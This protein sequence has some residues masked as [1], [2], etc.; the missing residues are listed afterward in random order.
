M[1]WTEGYVSEVN[2]TYG[3]Y[4]ELSPLKLALGTLI[5]LAQPIDSNQ[6]FT[7]CELACGQGYTTNIL[8]ATYPHAQ[9]YANDFNPNHIATARDLAAAAGMN[10]VKFFDDSFEEFLE[11]DL[12]QFDFISLHGIYSWISTKNRQAIVNFIRRNLKVGGLVYVSYNALPGWA[13]AMP[14]QALMLRH[15]ERISAPILNR[16]E[17][18]IDFAGQLMEANA[19]YFTQNPIL[20]SRHERLKDQNRYYLAHEY[21]NQEWNSFYFDEVAK[22]LEEAK[23]NYVGSANISDHLDVINIPPKG[24]EKLAQISDPIYREVV[25]DF[26]INTQFRRDIFVRGSIK[27]TPIEQV[28]KLQSMGLA[29]VVPRSKVKFTHQF[30]VGEVNLQ[31]AVYGAICDALDQNHLTFGQLQNHPKTTGIS[32]NNLYQAV[33]ILLGIGYIHPAVDEQTYQQR[34]KFTDAFNNAV[35]TKAINSEEYNYLASPWVGTGVP[36]NRV[37][38]LFLLAKANQRNGAE[39]VWQVICRQGKKMIQDGKT[40]ETAEENLAYL[41]ILYEEFSQERLLTLQKLGIE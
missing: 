34:K 22:E 8:A 14:M 6:E 36:V 25:R 4:G 17:Q 5:K 3:F 15:G 11:R 12:P 2:Y 40:L 10:N 37:E 26:F 27:I 23:L 38:Q 41:N 7:Y 32:L 20:K 16:I 13:A 18:A 28:E 24:Q 19:A 1:S 9:F 29:L 30:P 35:K 33:I 39:F 21:F 31:E